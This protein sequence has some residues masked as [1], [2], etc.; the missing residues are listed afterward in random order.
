MKNGKRLQDFVAFLDFFFLFCL[1]TGFQVFLLLFSQKEKVLVAA[2]VE[3]LQM[4]NCQIK[5]ILTKMLIF[6][7]Q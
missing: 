5:R 3:A 4:D 6:V 2:A 1:F 7:I